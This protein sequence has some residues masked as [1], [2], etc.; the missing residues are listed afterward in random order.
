MTNSSVGVLIEDDS[1]P[2]FGGNGAGSNTF[3][4]NTLCDFRSRSTATLNAVDNVWDDDVFS[5]FP[6]FQCTAGENLV[7]EGLGNVLYQYLPHQNEP[8]FQATAPIALLAPEYGAFLSTTQPTFIW[9]VSSRTNKMALAVWDTQPDVGL[10]GIE[11][12]EHIVLFWHSGMQTGS[13]GTVA[14]SDAA[15]PVGQDI[16][17]LE[18]PQPL[19]VG[20]PYYWAVW[21]WDAR[22]LQIEYS[23]E[24]R[25]FTVRP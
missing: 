20:R 8:L 9:S 12:A 6:Q 11:N 13:P 15:R 17:Q 3:A 19:Q 10:Y 18:P 25:V 1:E 7:V 5:F 16:E 4:L 21:E 22:G 14:F 2:K 23:S 24:V